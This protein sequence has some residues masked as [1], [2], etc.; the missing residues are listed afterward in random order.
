[1]KYAVQIVLGAMISVSCG[2]QIGSGIQA[3]IER[4]TSTQT[5]QHTDTQKAWRSCKPILL[6]FSKY[7]TKAENV[8]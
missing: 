3:L 7:G 8:S 5:H 4:H 6:F 2:I 1:M